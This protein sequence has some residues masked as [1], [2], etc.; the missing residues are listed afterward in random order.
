METGRFGKSHKCRYG[1]AMGI[2]AASRA[3]GIPSRTLRR[4]ILQNNYKKSLGPAACLGSDAEIKMASHIQQMQAA[5]LALSRKDVKILAFKLPQKLG[6][7]H[8][9]WVEEGRPG[10]TG[11]RRL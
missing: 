11:L 2:N 9:F 3:F 1:K 7:K 6:I 5:G 4:R 8:R 10:K